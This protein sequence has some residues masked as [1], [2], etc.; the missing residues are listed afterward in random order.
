M[1]VVS[2]TEATLMFVSRL[3]VIKD[4]QYTGAHLAQSDLS[5]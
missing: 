1:F 5:Y 2:R 4:F 3:G